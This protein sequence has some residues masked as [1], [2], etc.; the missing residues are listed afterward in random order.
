MAVKRKGDW[1]K[2]LLVDDDREMMRAVADFLSREGQVNVV[3]TMYDAQ[4]GMAAAKSCD[5]DLVLQDV[6]MPGMDPW[7]A[8]REIVDATSA[9][10]LF[11]TG[12]YATSYVGLCRRSGGSGVLSKQEPYETV[13]DAC[14]AVIC[15]EEY[16]S[17]V[18]YDQLYRQDDQLV[19]PAELLSDRDREVLRLYVEGQTTTQIAAEVG[20]S[21][22]QVYRIL[23]Q[24]RETLKADND[25]ELGAL[26]LR[27]NLIAPGVIGT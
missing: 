16:F 23:A 27:E 26:A 24:I 7:H 25:A 1:P 13:G 9:K 11:Y 8:C 2:V 18:F 15:G 3:G 12:G 21:G 5:I 20:V 17:S 4:A 6:S 10:V 22:S 14:R 19:P